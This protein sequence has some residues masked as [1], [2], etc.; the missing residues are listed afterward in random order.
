MFDGGASEK[1]KNLK[2]FKVCRTEMVYLCYQN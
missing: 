1:K 2:N